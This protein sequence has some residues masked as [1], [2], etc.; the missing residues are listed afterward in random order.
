MLLK[1]EMIMLKPKVK[2]VLISWTWIVKRDL[3]TGPYGAGYQRGNK[4][5]AG[6]LPCG[7]ATPETTVRPFW[8]W[9]ARRPLKDQAWRARVKF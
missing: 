6:H 3:P 7:Q 5:A 9:P 1:I 8:W 4:A 2:V